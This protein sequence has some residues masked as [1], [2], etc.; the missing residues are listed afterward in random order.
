M[1]LKLILASAL[2]ALGASSQA[3][4]S[5][6]G[7]HDGLEVS[8]LVQETTLFSDTYT[9]SL[10]SKSVVENSL[11]AF[12]LTGLYGLFKA[13]G[14]A[15]GSWAFGALQGPV[16]STTLD[17]GSYYYKILG[18]GSGIYSLS[19][20]AVAVA[21]PEPETYAMMLAGLGAIGFIARRRKQD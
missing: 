11:S 2:L 21:V 5:A 14:T 4:T 12:G 3:A 18:E 20:S 16:F 15:V 6:W 17:V 9:F 13:D 8:G 19:S 10:S 7:A 1:K